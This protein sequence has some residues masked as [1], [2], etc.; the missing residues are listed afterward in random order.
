LADIQRGKQEADIVSK[1]DE[2]R[3]RIVAQAATLFNQRG[4][5]GG[6]IS[7]LMKATGLEKG[8][9]Y[10]HFSS[11]EEL[12]AE[13]FEYAWKE[14]LDAR[15]RDLDTV[16]NSVDKLKQFTTNFVRRRSSVPGGCPLL[17]TAID[18]DDGNPVLRECA[19]KGL[20]AWR[21]RLS[22]IV[23]TGIKRKEIRRNVN[24]GRLA[25][26]IIASL[27]GALMIA[28]LERDREALEAAQAY[29]DHY[30]ETEVRTG[31]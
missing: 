3:Q 27:E 22:T 24:P 21:D 9:I 4:F 13:A 10:R 18:A 6:S 14:A 31:G 15:M 2:T 26:L 11:K 28:R 25:T 23:N 29:L 19:L 1:G 20:R 30:L 8:G 5:E 17:N 12:A 7:E 16:Q